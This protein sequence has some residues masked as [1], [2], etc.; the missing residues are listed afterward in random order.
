MPFLIEQIIK[1]INTCLKNG[2]Y[3]VA[4]TIA[5]TL[6][7]ICGKVEYPKDNNSS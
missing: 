4:L 6:P 1:E 2:C 5:L 3:I 7:D